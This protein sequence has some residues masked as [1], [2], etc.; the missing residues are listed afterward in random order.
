MS[1]NQF[2]YTATNLPDA[3]EMR[4]GIVAAEWNEHITGQLVDG[5]VKTLTENGVK[6]NNI[7]VRHVPGSY[8]LIYGAAALCKSRLFDAVIVIGSVIRGDTTHFDYNFEG[9]TQG[10]AR[11]N[12]NG[13]IPVIFGLLTTNNEQQA[14][15]RSG[16]SLG[17]KG[18]EFALT[19]IK[20]IDFAWQ[21]QK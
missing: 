1:S 17:N 18:N 6:P 21:L 19:A 15:D 13:S 12:A 4:I 8:E 9:V 2:Q 14:K 3:S 10:I 16:G 20:M 5:A 11:L 7:N